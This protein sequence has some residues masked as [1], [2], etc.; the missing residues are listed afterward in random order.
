MTQS[1]YDFQ[2]LLDNFLDTRDA[3]HSQSSRRF[4][5]FDFAR[6]GFA[7]TAPADSWAINH[8]Q[9]IDER[10][11]GELS[12]DALADHGAAAPAWR[13]FTCFAL[14][15]LLGLYQTEQLVGLQFEAADAQLAGFM[16]LHSSL[17]ETF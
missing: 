5:P 4:D 13:A 1:P 16:F 9:F 12:D 14:G 7:K 3:I 15:Y 6:R 17:F 10:C 11:D 2:P 8:Q